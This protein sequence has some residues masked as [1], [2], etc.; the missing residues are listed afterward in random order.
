M[1]LRYVT[2]GSEGAMARETKRVSLLKQFKM[3]ISGGN[4]LDMAVGMVMAATFSAFV[5]S[6]VNDIIMPILTA[7]MG[8]GFEDIKIAIGPNGTTIQVG[9][10]LQ[11]IVTLLII[12]LLMFFF[13]KLLYQSGVLTPREA[14]PESPTCPFCKEDIREGAVICPHCGSRLDSE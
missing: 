1:N 9:M 5:V 14:L 3:F 13:L 11:N 8:H 12:T 6:L 10:F 2:E 4:V 7:L